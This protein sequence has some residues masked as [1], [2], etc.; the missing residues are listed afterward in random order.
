MAYAAPTRS[1]FGKS[2]GLLAG[3]VVPVTPPATEEVVEIPVTCAGS[4]KDC[5]SDSGSDNGTSSNR[6]DCN[7]SSDD[8][9]SQESHSKIITLFLKHFCF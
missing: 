1:V 2:K 3:D 8:Q 9:K 7:E 6:S 5:K 4:S